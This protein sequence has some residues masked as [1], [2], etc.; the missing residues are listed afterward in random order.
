LRSAIVGGLQASG[1]GQREAGAPKTALLARSQLEKTAEPG[2][3][4]RL[5]LWKRGVSFGDP[6]FGLSV[7]SGLNFVDQSFD[8]WFRTATEPVV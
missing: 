4:A 8:R 6:V 5:F 3:L 1:S 2:W 7:S